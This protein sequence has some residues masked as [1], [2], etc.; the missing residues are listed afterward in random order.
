LIAPNR[1]EEKVKSLG[2]APLSL[3]YSFA[4]HSLSNRFAGCDVSDSA[5]IEVLLLW[6]GF[7]RKVAQSALSP[8]T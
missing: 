5:K 2:D 3:I 4:D 6:L 8:E 1:S 7:I